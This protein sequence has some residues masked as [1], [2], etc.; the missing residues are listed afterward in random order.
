VRGEIVLV[1]SPA[2]EN[3]EVNAEEKA[4]ELIREGLQGRELREALVV[5][6]VPRNT[7]YELSLKNW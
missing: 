4:K 1:I 5:M 6:G 7:A 3:N 2:A